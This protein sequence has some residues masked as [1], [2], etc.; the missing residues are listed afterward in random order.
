MSP[1]GTAE[2]R[3]A[4][5]WRHG[6]PRGHGH[7]RGALTSRLNRGLSSALEPKA[8]LWGQGLRQFQPESGKHP[9]RWV[10][11]ALPDREGAG[12]VPGAALP[13]TSS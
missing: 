12:V 11:P 10:G 1:A 13:D 2:P 9:G 8:G 3:R 4:E 7:W 5:G 6:G